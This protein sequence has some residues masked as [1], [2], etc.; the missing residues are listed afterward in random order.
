M[1]N[2]KHWYV[3]GPLKTETK[4]TEKDPLMVYALRLWTANRLLMKGWQLIGPETLG[5][6]LFP[7]GSLPAPRVLQN[8]LDR[9]LESHIARAEG[10]VLKELQGAMLRSRSCSSIVVFIGVFL[11]LHVR[12][13]D[14]WRL[15]H[16]IINPDV[17][18]VH[19]ILRSM[20]AD[21]HSVL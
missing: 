8:Q 18:S 20:V 7:D 10:L 5:M 19:L 1:L 4:L 2:S 11:V 6:P 15:A 9:I 12:E 3:P 13:R 14:I 17:V 21:K 16:W